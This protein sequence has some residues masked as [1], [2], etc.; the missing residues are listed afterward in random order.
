MITAS[1]QRDLRFDSFFEKN[2]LSIF[3]ASSSN[4]FMYTTETQ[5]RVRY[6]E[7]DRM[8]Y[9]YYGN[10]AQYFEVARVESLRSL[11]VSYREMED[12]GVLLP[13]LDFSVKFFKPAFYD[14]M[15]TIK[16]S[17]TELP[18]A[19][20]IFDYE[21]YNEQGVLLNKASTTLV[22]VN[23]NNGRPTAAPAAILEKLK[24]YFSA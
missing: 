24:D 16:T 5:I 12:D 21:T 22:F 13:V 10:Y 18:K 2:I 14:E 7:T 15:L 23:K 6:S 20:I 3:F 17:I 9:V 8:S 1:I 19:R 4:N 11:G